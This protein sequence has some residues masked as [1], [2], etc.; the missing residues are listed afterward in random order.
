MGLRAGA[1][2][3]GRAAGERAQATPHGHHQQQ[4]RPA[5][6]CALR[7]CCARCACRAR[8][9]AR[10][11]RVNLLLV[12][13]GG[14]DARQH[15]ARPGRARRVTLAQRHK[16]EVG[17]AAQTEA[18][19]PVVVDGQGRRIPG[20]AGATPCRPDSSQ[21]LI[22]T[23]CLATQQQAAARQAAAR[24]Q[25]THLQQWWRAPVRASSSSTRTPTCSGQRVGKDGAAASV[26]PAR[27]QPAVRSRRHAGKGQSRSSRPPA[28][29]VHAADSPQPASLTS[30]DDRKVRLTMAA[31]TTTDPTC[32]SNRRVVARRRS[33]LRIDTSPAAWPQCRQPSRQQAAGASGMQAEQG[34][35]WRARRTWQGRRKWTASTEAVTQGPRANVLAASPAQMSIQLSTVPPCAAGAA[36]RSGAHGLC[37][38]AGGSSGGAP[39]VA[40]TVGRPAAPTRC[41]S[42]TMQTSSP[43]ESPGDTICAMTMRVAAMGTSASIGRGTL[44]LAVAAATAAAAERG[45]SGGRAAEAARSPSPRRRS[46]AEGSTSREC[47][48]R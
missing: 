48:W 46:A 14:H 41:C 47:R 29:R 2:E 24:R 38:R 21:Q 12:P 6:C 32:T 33:V 35:A 26:S 17:A 18:N 5:A 43:L 4:Q 3:Q 16:G 27:Q 19:G 23:V 39:P 8:P 7:C 42:L 25:A 13:V 37:I 20:W 40:D 30:M 10:G 45:D 9:P 22:T 1:S 36:R 11:L 31:I 15:G 28:H 44:P 34:A